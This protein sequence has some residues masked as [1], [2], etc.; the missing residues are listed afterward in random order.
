M[1]EKVVSYLKKIVYSTD[2][3]GNQITTKEDRTVTVER[4]NKLRATVCQGCRHNYY[5]YQKGASSRGDVAVAE[6]EGCW[7]LEGIDLRRKKEPCSMHN[8]Y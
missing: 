5:N 3:E 2:S 4:R 7:H 8:K 1:K 6:D